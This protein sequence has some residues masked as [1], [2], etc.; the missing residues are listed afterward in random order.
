[1]KI[2]LCGHRTEYLAML[3]A[4]LKDL[5]YDCLQTSSAETAAATLT[6][7]RFDVLV[8]C[9]APGHIDAIEVLAQTRAS[10]PRTRVLMAASEPTLELVC[11]ALN[12]HAWAFFP[13]EIELPDLLSALAEIE[14]ETAD[15][16]KREEQ[17]SRLALEFARL[18]Q[19]YDDL[20]D[21]GPAG[22]HKTTNGRES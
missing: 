15:F 17:H 1:M 4:S 10:S 18:K 7:A 11:T 8:V 13:R 5:E 9:H 12:L 14:T 19:A 22:H 20:R 16:R 6:A 3:A 21:A 2:L